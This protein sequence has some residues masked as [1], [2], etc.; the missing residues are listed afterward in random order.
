MYCIGLYTRTKSKLIDAYDS[1]A[2][3]AI[4]LGKDI[5]LNSTLSSTY[6]KISFHINGD[7]DE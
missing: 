2:D 1:L 3:T 6:D 7:R 5:V 4:M